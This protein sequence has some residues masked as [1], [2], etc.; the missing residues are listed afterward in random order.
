MTDY[1]ER[2]R[3]LTSIVNTHHVVPNTPY[4]ITDGGITRNIGSLWKNRIFKTGIIIVLPCIVITLVILMMKPEFLVTKG[5]PSNPDNKKDKVK[6]GFVLLLYI[7]LQ[8]AAFGI[9]Y[10][11][12]R[13]LLLPS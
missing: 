10:Y 7:L 2:L 12:K 3:H 9:L 5:D 1:T 11:F 4:T 13:T 8:S 6:V